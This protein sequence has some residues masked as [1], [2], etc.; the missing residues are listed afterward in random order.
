MGKTFPA[1]SFQEMHSDIGC[2]VPGI[3]FGK[4]PSVSEQLRVFHLDS[5]R[6]MQQQCAVVVGIHCFRFLLANG[7][8]PNSLRLQKLLR[9]YLLTADVFQWFTHPKT[10]L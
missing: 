2:T 3:V 9:I 8:S 10:L 4:A 6:H 1:I 7:T 5:S